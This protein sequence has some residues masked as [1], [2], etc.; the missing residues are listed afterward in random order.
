M[1][2][3]MG[4]CGFHIEFENG[5]TVSVQFGY[6]S[7]CNPVKDF[8]CSNIHLIGT[9][10]DEKVHESYTAEVAI[11]EKGGEWITKECPVFKTSDEVKGWL[12]PK[13]V[14]ETLNWASKR[15]D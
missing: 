12:S 15:C 6:G 11:W 14:L 4:N 10:K 13:E 5:V 8:H 9:E 7:Y 2:K 1:F 3:V